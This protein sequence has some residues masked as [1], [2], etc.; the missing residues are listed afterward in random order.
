MEKI[1]TVIFACAPIMLSAIAN[2]GRSA[3]PSTIRGVY[4]LLPASVLALRLV[5]S[6]QYPGR[7]DLPTLRDAKATLPYLIPAILILC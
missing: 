6:A 4:D 2:I 3:G 1:P 7:D 5:P